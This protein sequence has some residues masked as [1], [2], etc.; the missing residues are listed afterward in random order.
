MQNCTDEHFAHALWFQN[1]PYSKKLERNRKSI[2]IFNIIKIQLLFEKYLDEK[3][4]I[5]AFCR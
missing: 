1:S 2:K 5:L 3:E 4:L